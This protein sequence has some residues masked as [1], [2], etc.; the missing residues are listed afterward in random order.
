MVIIYIYARHI[1]DG[2]C[3]KNQA[4]PV[5]I[6][7]TIIF[8]KVPDGH[9]MTVVQSIYFRSKIT[10]YSF[11]RGMAT[12]AFTSGLSSDLICSSWGIGVQMHIKNIYII[13]LKIKLQYQN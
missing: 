13:P 3:H 11:R 2:T 10:N 4:F 1:K 9:L 5:I 6:I 12:F 8:Y 7:E